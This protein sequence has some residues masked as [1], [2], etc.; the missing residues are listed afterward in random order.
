MNA[1][2]LLRELR[3]PLAVLAAASVL[4]GALWL[5]RPSWEVQ[6]GLAVVLALANATTLLWFGRRSGERF[7]AQGVRL[8]TPVQKL[9]VWVPLLVIP[10]LVGIALLASGHYYDHFALRS[11]LEMLTGGL[12]VFFAAL[13]WSRWKR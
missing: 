9:L 12:L 6:T 11:W 1:A 5:V 10:S 4:Y 8:G 13:F 3:A 2:T 7:R